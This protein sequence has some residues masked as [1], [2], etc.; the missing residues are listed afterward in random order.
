MRTSESTQITTK[1]IPKLVKEA[2]VPIENIKTDCTSKYT[3]SKRIDIIISKNK[4]SSKEFDDKII[5]IIE[6]KQEIANVL[7]IYEV[8]KD[9]KKIVK[10]DIHKLLEK[11]ITLYEKNSDSIDYEYVKEKE[12]FNALVQ[13]AWKARRMSLPF[14]GVSNVKTTVFYHTKTLLPLEI[15]RTVALVKDAKVIHEDATEE[16]L[17]LPSYNLMV[18]LSSKINDSLRVCDYRSLKQ[19]EQNEKVSMNEK[20][21]IDFLTRIHNEFYKN[22]LKGSKKYLGDI[23]LTFL[24]FKY[25]EERVQIQGTID[26]YKRDEIVLWSDWVTEEELLSDK[27]EK[28]ESMGSKIR[29][30]IKNQLAL[31]KNK[32]DEKDEK[33]KEYV[34]GYE[35]EYREFYGVLADIENIPQNKS[36]YRFLAKIYKELVGINTVTNKKEN[37]LYLHACNFD[38]YGA[39]YEKFKDKDE[40]EELGQYYTKRHISRILARVTLKPF[41]DEIKDSILKKQNELEKT[42]NE[43]T[44]EEIISILKEKYSKIKII[45][46]SC[47]TGGLLTEC[48]ECLEELYRTI[49]NGRHEEI[50]NILSKEMFTGLDIEE[51]CIKKAKLNMF[52]AGDGHTDL[53]RGNSL[54]AFPGQKNK[55]NDNCTQNKWNVIVSNP[56]YGKGKEYLFMKKYIRALPYGGRIGIIIPNGILENPSKESYRKFILSNIKIESIISLN[57]FVFAPYTKQKTYI[58][59]GYKRNKNTIQALEKEVVVNENGENNINGINTELDKLKDKIWSYI[60]DFDGYNLSDNRWETDL[61]IIEDERPKYVHNDTYEVINDYLKDDIIKINQLDISGNIMGVKNEHGEYIL[62]KSKYIELNKDV[63][64]E[65]HYNLLPEYYMRPYSPEFITEEEFTNEVNLIWEQIKDLIK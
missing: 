39:I 63:I 12:W 44:P 50:E 47:G 51:D 1:Y 56:P 25:L 61:M 22:S 33:T 21:F 54:E 59:V 9:G 60:L 46:P 52:F 20:Q 7:N 34:S 13:G 49:L 42:G 31:L 58:L 35:K 55:L 40:K 19:D 45:D 57:K 5:A 37:S 28:I 65:N 24:F 15:R 29:T 26:R 17:G 14:F 36:G 48:Y 30:K 3:D 6:V 32:D 38:V 11:N 53:N 18:D 62:T 2:K 27:D 10:D 23:I 41:V 16:L 8:D 64:K 4:N 43:I